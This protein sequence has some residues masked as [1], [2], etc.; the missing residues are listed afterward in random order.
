MRNLDSVAL[1]LIEKHKAGTYHD[2]SQAQAA[3][4]SAIVAA[5]QKERQ[6]A[7]YD[8]AEAIISLSRSEDDKDYVK[9]LE[10]IGA[11]LEEA[12]RW[13][14]EPKADTAGNFPGRERMV[15]RLFDLLKE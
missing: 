3:L 5:L 7:C 15:A 12:G 13:P 9:A 6:R 11:C 10:A 4:Q 1:L 2:A 8:C 14:R